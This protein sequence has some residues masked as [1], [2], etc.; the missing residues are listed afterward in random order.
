[1]LEILDTA[2]TVSKRNAPLFWENSMGNFRSNGDLS[3]V[4][5]FAPQVC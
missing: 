5:S 2:G 3:T 4:Y 1:M